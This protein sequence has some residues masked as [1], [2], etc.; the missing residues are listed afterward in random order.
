M[1]KK[2]VSL[3][4]VVCFLFLIGCAAHVHKV[5]NGPQGNQ[6]VT[7][8]QWYIAWGLAPLNEVDTNAMA[9]NSTD[10]QIKTEITAVDVIINA[11]TGWLSLYSRTVTVT[12]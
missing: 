9:G 5:G 1:L 11:I 12:K 3:V 8:R 4:L 2:A 6:V 7:K 10:Y